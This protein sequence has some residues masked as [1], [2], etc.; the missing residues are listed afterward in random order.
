MYVASQGPLW[1]AGGDRGLFKTT[2]GG[3][4]WQQVLKISD[5]TG[6]SDVVMDPKNPLVLY[7]SAYQ[8]RRAVGQMIGGGPEGG[9]YK[10]TDGGKTW[11]KLT[12]GLPKGDMGRAGLAID[13]RKTPATV[14]A[15][16]DAKRDESGFYRSD[17]AGATWARIGKMPPAA[18]GQR[19]GA[20]SGP[21]AGAPAAATPAAARGGAAPAGAQ[22][23]PAAATPA[24]GSARR[25]PRHRRHRRPLPRL[26]SA[27]ARPTT[28]TAA[29][30]PRTTT[31]STS[32]PTSPTR[33]GR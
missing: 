26:D 17:D 25:V 28:G 18:G 5:D 27:A 30:A 8:R 16:I 7:A 20:A 12:N 11:K 24:G 21:A 2:D 23:T 32:I 22:A 29:A 14:F 3:A 15:I 10:T 4:T 1:S 19:G 33:S 6:V 9:I 13:G 31:R